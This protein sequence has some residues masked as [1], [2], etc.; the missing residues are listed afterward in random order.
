MPAR[1]ATVTPLGRPGQAR[2]GS[3]SAGPDGLAAH[4]DS[5]GLGGDPTASLSLSES[6]EQVRACIGGANGLGKMTNV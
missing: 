1:L 2:F 6:L 4:G 3:E 5:D